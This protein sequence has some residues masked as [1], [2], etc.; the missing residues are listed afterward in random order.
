MSLVT[1]TETFCTSIVLATLLGKL[2]GSPEGV[3]KDEV[4]IKNMSSRKIKSVMEAMLKA[5]STLF[6]DCKFI[7]TA[8]LVTSQ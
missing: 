8:V 1:V 2:T 7:L 3:I 4:S 6:L 5:A